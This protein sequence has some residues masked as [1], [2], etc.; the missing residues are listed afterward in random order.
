MQ[1]LPAL[2]VGH[3]DDATLKP[4]EQVDPE[5]AVGHTRILLRDDR[6][7]EHRLTAVEIEPVGEEIGFSLPLIPGRHS[8]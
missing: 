5:L 1:I 8:T 3:A 2:C 4:A 6:M 7:V